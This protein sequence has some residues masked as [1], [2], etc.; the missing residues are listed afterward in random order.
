MSSMPPTVLTSPPTRSVK[1]KVVYVFAAMLLLQ[2]T[3][4]ISLEGA[5]PNLLYF[6]IYCALLASGV[7]V[8]SVNR[9][10]LIVS[11]SA[12]VL[13]L[14]FG[15]PWVISGDTI[16]WLAIASYASLIFFQITIIIVL[17]GFIFEAD[18][19]SRDVLFAAITI[20]ILFGNVFSATYMIIQELQ[21]DAFVATHLNNPIPWQYM[22]YF[23]YA[24]LTTLGYG[25]IIPVSPWAQSVV[26]VEAMLGLLY[27]AVIIGRMA[28]R[29]RGE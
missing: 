7:Y 29:Y 5:L 19:I 21:P 15:I 18:Q 4:P 12:A 23:S 13:S 8:A 11:V 17:L 24:T 28:S 10:H 9:T 26:A 20:Y 25:D 3:Y 1:G 14:G 27:I 2:L 22:I 6:S 16:V